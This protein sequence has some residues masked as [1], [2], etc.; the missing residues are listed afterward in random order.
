MV[1]GLQRLPGS[2]EAL[3]RVLVSDRVAVQAL[4]CSTPSLTRCQAAPFRD[5]WTYFVR[6][7][8]LQEYLST[9]GSAGQDVQQAVQQVQDACGEL[10]Q[11]LQQVADGAQSVVDAASSPN[12]AGTAVIELQELL[13]RYEV[14]DE[15]NEL[16][17]WF[18]NNPGVKITIESGG[19]TGTDYGLWTSSYTNL[20][21]YLTHEFGY[22]LGADMFGAPFDWRLHLDGMELSGQMDILASQ[23]QA[24]VRANCGRKAVLIGHSM[25]GLVAFHLLHRSA[26]WTRRYV[27][28]FIP[29]SAPFGG[30]ADQAVAVRMGAVDFNINDWVKLPMQRAA[31]EVT[32]NYTTDVAVAV[33]AD[34]GASGIGAL[35]EDEVIAIPRRIPGKLPGRLG[36]NRNSTAYVASFMGL[37][38]SPGANGSN[39]PKLMLAARSS[40][41]KVVRR[42]IS[43][44][45]FRA[46]MG[47]PGLSMLLP[48]P[49]AYGS[50]R[51]I[52]ITPRRTYTTSMMGQLMSD[53]GDSATYQAWKQVHQLDALVAKGPVPGVATHCIYAAGKDTTVTWSFPNIV[54][55]QPLITSSIMLRSGGDGTVGVQSLRQCYK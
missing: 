53:I 3:V 16:L 11:L 31:A 46:T 2:D 37:P 27:Q 17:A 22:E 10:L 55:L 54:K 38:G 12:T 40:I 32:A 35:H 4:H 19:P 36:R 43:T 30:T 1:A 8:A 18:D 39:G 50:N 13:V 25:G 26:S 51:R 20:T 9:Q 23:V 34:M 21:N 41:D 28:G 14:A 48:Y 52:V 6:T 45:F 44:I 42:Y 49:S 47:L 5:R 7:A 29:V 24:A 15:L 33:A